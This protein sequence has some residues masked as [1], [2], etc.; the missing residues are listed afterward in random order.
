M[1]AQRTGANTLC[2]DGRDRLLPANSKSV[3]ATYAG[4]CPENSMTIASYLHVLLCRSCPLSVYRPPLGFG[5]M[6]GQHLGCA[7]APGRR[8]PTEHRCWETALRGHTDRPFVAY[9]MRSLRGGFRI[10]ADRSRQIR[11]ADHNLSLASQHPNVITKYLNTEA[12]LGR[13]LSTR[14]HLTGRRYRLTRWE[15]SPKDKQESGGSSQTSR[16]WWA[17]APTM[18]ST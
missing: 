18:P 4:S 1:H 15:R 9:N 12:G 17:I 8:H 14:R 13:M 2:P 10:G 7:D 16:T 3:E 6:R 11:A 5:L